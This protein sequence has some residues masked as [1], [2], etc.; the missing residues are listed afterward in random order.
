[1][2]GRPSQRFQ[3]ASVRRPDD[4]LWPLGCLGV[5]IGIVAS[6]CGLA[7]LIV[8]TLSGGTLPALPNSHPSEDIIIT[9]QEAYLTQTV[10]QN[11]PALPSGL[12]SD[13]ELDLQPSNALVFTGRLRSTLPGIALQGDVSGVIHL[14]VRDGQLAVSF[15]DLKVL[16][17]ALPAIGNTLAN[18]MMAGMNQTL[19]SQLREGL[20]QD[21]RLVDLIT[22]DRQMILRGRW[23][24]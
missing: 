22:N 3:D 17:F 23:Q 24:P 19:N 6:L 7:G 20:G 14:A 15:S 5:G 1:M 13:V 4:R 8:L 10:A 11:L 2:P 18:E 12:A 16:G 9:V 21:F